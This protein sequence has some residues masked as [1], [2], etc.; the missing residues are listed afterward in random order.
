MVVWLDCV[1]GFSSPLYHLF[2]GACA[3]SGS[4]TPPLDPGSGDIGSW[5]LM[6]ATG[7]ASCMAAIASAVRWLATLVFQK[8]PGGAW[9]GRKVILAILKRRGLKKGGDFLRDHLVYGVCDRIG[10][11]RYASMRTIM[12]KCAA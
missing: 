11:R 3:P 1:T 6:S 10:M 4:P 7:A 2:P 12:N 8:M 5:L 9:I